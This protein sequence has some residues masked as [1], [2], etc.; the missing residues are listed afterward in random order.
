VLALHIEV[1]DH[2]PF[3]AGVEDWA[4]LSAHLNAVRGEV[5]KR[6]TDDLD[7]SVNGMTR[8]DE[9]GVAHH[10]RWPR[11]PLKLG[12]TVRVTLVEASSTEP[13]IKRYRADKDVRE[14][15]FTDDEVREMR[16]QD[17]LAL[18]RDFEG[19]A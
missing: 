6:E 9:N 18:K 10:V 14:N 19:E 17:Y 2:P 12:S 15:P 1:D 16:R 13:P 11:I 3:S 7:F 8:E 5:Y 4:I